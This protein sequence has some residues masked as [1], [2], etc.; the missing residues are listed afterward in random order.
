M[1][2]FGHPKTLR[3]ALSASVAIVYNKLKN[4]I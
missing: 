2:N 4:K 1:D 3:K